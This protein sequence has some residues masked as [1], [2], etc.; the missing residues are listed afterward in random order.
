MKSFTSID[1]LKVNKFYVSFVLFVN[2]IFRISNAPVNYTMYTLQFCLSRSSSIE[3]KCGKRNPRFL[4]CRC[5]QVLLCEE[6]LGRQ[7]I[8][9]LRDSV[10][11][12]VAPN[13]MNPHNPSTFQTKDRMN[14]SGHPSNSSSSYQAVKSWLAR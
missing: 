7:R 1:H 5:K 11:G 4:G 12:I 13:D 9:G 3:R 8:K 2:D 14:V 6:R 10:K